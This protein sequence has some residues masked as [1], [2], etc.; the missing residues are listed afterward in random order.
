MREGGGRNKPKVI[1]FSF[2]ELLF[3][4]ASEPFF[5]ADKFMELLIVFLVYDKQS[6]LIMSMIK[7]SNSLRFLKELED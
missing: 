2:L 5:G 4:F 7:M 3:D 6:T 1:F